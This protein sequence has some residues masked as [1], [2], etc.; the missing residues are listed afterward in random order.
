MKSLHIGEVLIACLVTSVITVG[1]FSQTYACNA[2]FIPETENSDITKENVLK[3][4]NDSRVEAGLGPLV[5]NPILNQVA[6]AKVEDMIVR[7]YLSHVNP[8]GEKVYVQIRALGY[9]Y[10]KAGENIAATYQ[11]VNI[12]HEG[13]MNSEL[14]RGNIL[15]PKY[16]EIGIGVAIGDYGKYKNM[17]YVVTVFG[18][19]K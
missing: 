7:Q 9:D 5:E 8:E 3:L 4:I 13:W 19:Q 15:D 16:K 1:I 12:Q 18:V 10:A 14:H 2:Q 11:D 17:I 6:H